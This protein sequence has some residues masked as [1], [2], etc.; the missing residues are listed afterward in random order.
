MS[1]IREKHLS[2]HFLMP[3][4]KDAQLGENY[5]GHCG[6]ELRKFPT[7]RWNNA[8]VNPV[9]QNP[10]V[11]PQA[12]YSASNSPVMSQSYHRRNSIEP[13]KLARPFSVQTERK[14]PL[15]G[16][17]HVTRSLPTSKLA[18]EPVKKS[19]KEAEKKHINESAGTSKAQK[20]STQQLDNRSKCLTLLQQR[21]P[22]VIYL[23]CGKLVTA[24]IRLI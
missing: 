6:T 5:C 11:M 17:E 14:I 22:M 13:A 2:G 4:V 24:L 3:R 15:Y 7:D 19:H 18:N 1:A 21:K 10:T 9:F 23:I 16:P 12:S 20:L 8:N